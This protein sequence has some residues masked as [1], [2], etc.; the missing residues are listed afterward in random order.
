MEQW[1]KGGFSQEEYKKM[2]EKAMREIE[3]LAK[4]YPQPAAAK[5]EET[6]KQPDYIPPA[7]QAIQPEKTPGRQERYHPP[8]GESLDSAQASGKE[9]PQ[10]FAQ[11]APIE[12]NAAKQAETLQQRPRQRTVRFIKE[13]ATPPVIEEN[14]QPEKEW[15]PIKPTGQEAYIKAPPA[16]SPTSGDPIKT[17]EMV[18]VPAA[19]TVGENTAEPQTPKISQM[20]IKLQI[21]DTPVQIPV[22]LAPA[23]MPVDTARGEGNA[24]VRPAGPDEARPVFT[25]VAPLRADAM[26]TRP[27]R[28]EPMQNTGSAPVATPGPHRQKTRRLRQPSQTCL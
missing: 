27:Y 21:G 13:A 6:P 15:A 20:N 3:E 8:G 1:N 9:K 5:R 17:A 11:E 18:F 28:D 26:Q 25:P 19:G 2:R 24:P 10:P 14:T 22:N 7:K 23:Q 4:K 16:Q 12:Q